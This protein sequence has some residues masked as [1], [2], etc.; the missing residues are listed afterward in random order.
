MNSFIS[1]ETEN[2]FYLQVNLFE[3]EDSP[4]GSYTFLSAA[5]VSAG[6]ML[7]CVFLEVFSVSVWKT[8]G[9]GLLKKTPHAMIHLNM[10]SSPWD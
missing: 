1:L 4:L 3:E 10:E 9:T 8:R 7:L 5:E 6:P 2:S